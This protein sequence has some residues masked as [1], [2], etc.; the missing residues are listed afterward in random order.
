L[1]PIGWRPVIPGIAAKDRPR[2]EAYHG[3]AAAPG[4][5]R[6][7]SVTGSNERIGAVTGHAANAPYRAAP[8]TR[9]ANGAG[10]PCSY[11]AGIIYRHAHQ[12]AMKTVAVL[13]TPISNIKNVTHDAERRSLLLDRCSEGRAVV[14]SCRLHVYRPAWVDGARVHAKRNDVMF[15]GRAAIRRDHCVQKERP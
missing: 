4:P 8:Y 1:D 3:F 11:A 5:P 9:I 13:H 14:L 7:G 12:P 2:L 6:E 10:G 15:L